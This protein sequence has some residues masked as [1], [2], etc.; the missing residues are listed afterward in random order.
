MDTRAAIAAAKRAFPPFSRTT[1]AERIALLNRLADAVEA[2]SADL[3][4]A[5]I[6]EYGAPVARSAWTSAYAVGVF[7]LAAQTLEGYDFTRQDRHRRVTMEPLGVVGLITPWNANA[8]FI[9]GKLAMA[10]ASGSTCGDQAERDERD[11]DQHRTGGAARGRPA[12]G[13]VQH[14]QRPRRRGW[15]GAEPP[16]PTSPRSASPARPRPAAPSCA[17]APRRIKRVTLELGGK[18]PMVIL[19]DADFAEAMPLAL[20]AGFGNSGQACIAGT[21]ILVPAARLDEFEA[22]IKAA[23]ATIKS[24]RSA[25]SGNRDRPDGQPAA[26]GPRPVL[27]PHGPGGGRDPACRRRGRPEGEREGWFVRPTVFTN[28]TNYM[29]I[30]REEI[31]GPVLS[32]IPYSDDEEAIAIA[33]DTDYGLQA[34]VAGKDETRARAVADRLVKNGP[35]DH[36]RR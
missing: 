5:M 24:G 25:R 3:S 18:S 26:M 27:Y 9:C 4:E 30:A 35:G 13:R 16:A 10:I 36:Q 17:P 8:G 28:V 32:I 29:T 12:A 34:Y 1:K 33:N 7:R 19:D 22:A 20:M 23:V 15:R 14:R 31:F 11:P 2:R 21:R 6:E